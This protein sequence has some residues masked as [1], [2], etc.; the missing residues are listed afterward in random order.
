MDY[1]VIE[2]MSSLMVCFSIISV[3]VIGLVYFTVSELS[4][5]HLCSLCFLSVAF[6][7]IRRLRIAQPLMILSHLI[8]GAIYLT[9]LYYLVLEGTSEALGA[10]VFLGI[11]AF[12]LFIHSLTYRYSK[13]T[14]HI[15]F[16]NLVV[17]LSVHTVLLFT[18]L[19]MGSTDKTF[20]VL[21]DSIMLVVLHFA[22][23]QLDVFDTKYYHNLHSSTQPIKDMKN[24][25]HYSI[26]LIF[27]GIMF[28]LLL[29]LCMPIDT[30]SSIVS[31]I[32]GAIFT[33]F[34][35]LIQLFDKWIHGGS[36]EYSNHGAEL[37][38]PDAED[39][40]P[41]EASV[42]ITVI[43]I[44][45]IALFFFFIL[46]NTIRR[47][48]KR[49]RLA[50]DTEKVIENK[51]VIDIIEDVPK[52]KKASARHMDFG[53]GYEAKIR[54]QYYNTVTRAIRKGI[55]VKKASS[56]RQIEEQIKEMGDPSISE[57][58]SRYESVRYNKK[59]G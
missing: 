48:I 2:I 15:L 7:F 56:P 13:K 40:E 31:H 45:A 55:T 41:S 47:L 11:C 17:L 51:A 5:N 24:Q 9:I 37:I 39:Y 46:I 26:V 28:S 43:L 16:D 44:V 6:V 21:L 19:I 25:N 14:K 29:L 58:T 12:S 32:I 27:G 53:E 30:I 22:A 20:Y 42:I 1:L 18:L 36:S 10:T 23:R 35:Y 49:F 4:Y 57:L 38:Q 34:G 33:F 3:G 50:E 52:A 54:K 59:N 8:A